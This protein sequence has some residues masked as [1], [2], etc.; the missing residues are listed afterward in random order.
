[1]PWRYTTNAVDTAHALLADGCRLWALEHDER[2]EPL[3]S[4]APPLTSGSEGDGAPIVLVAGNENA[5]VDPDL[6]ALCERVLHIPMQGA[7]E[8]LN[9]AIAFGIAAYYTRFGHSGGAGAG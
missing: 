2:S 1:M 3:F 4:L 8:S 9:V 6:L 7:K 5:G